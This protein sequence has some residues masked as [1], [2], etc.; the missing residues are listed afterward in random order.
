MNKNHKTKTYHG[1]SVVISTIPP[2]FLSLMDH[3]GHLNGI[4][5]GVGGL[6]GP[7]LVWL[8]DNVHTSYN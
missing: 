1:H 8:W 6:L 4:G 7:W 5:C 3:V 2:F